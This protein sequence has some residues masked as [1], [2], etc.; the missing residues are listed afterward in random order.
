MNLGIIIPQGSWIDTYSTTNGR[1]IQGLRLAAIYFLFV[2]GLIA[3]II[4]TAIFGPAEKLKMVPW[5][6]VDGFLQLLLYLIGI[7]AV[8]GAAQYVGKRATSD[9]LVVKALSD[10]KMAEAVVPGSVSTTTTVSSS[11]APTG[12]RGP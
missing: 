11:T 5:D 3:W 7:L 2:L 9:P 6:I 8:A 12:E 4:A 1:I 10:A